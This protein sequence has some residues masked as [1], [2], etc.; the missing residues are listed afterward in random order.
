MSRYMLWNDALAVH[1]FNAD[2]AGKEVYLHTTWDLIEKTGKVLGEP[3][4]GFLE[5]V[6]DGPPWVGTGTLCQRAYQS[7]K[8]WRSRGLRLPP[9]IGYLCLFVLAATVQGDFAPHAYYPRLWQ[10]LGSEDRLMPPSFDRIWE[11]WEDLEQWSMRD[12]RGE[13]GV[14]RARTIGRHIHVGYPLAQALLSAPDWKQLPAIFAAAGL[15]PVFST[16]EELQTALLIH[17][18]GLLS[19][20]TTRIL[21]AEYGD[22]ACRHLLELVREELREWD[23]AIPAQEN[24]E[25]ATI[26]KAV[27]WLRI[28]LRSV[29]YVANTA[30]AVIRYQLN[31]EFPET[32]LCLSLPD[33]RTVTALPYGDGWSMPLCLPGDKEL[34]A[35][36]LG[37][38]DDVVLKDK[39][40]GWVFRLPGR[41]ARVFTSGEPWGLP[42]LV[43]VPFLLS[44]RLGIAV[45]SQL[46]DALVSWGRASCLGFT[47]PREIKG[48]PQ[49]WSL[50]WIDKV[51]TPTNLPR[52]L[53]F[54][55]PPP[56]TRI[57]L[58]GGI[59]ANRGDVF[60]TFAPPRVQVEGG[61]PGARVYCNG[62]PAEESGTGGLYTLPKSILEEPMSRILIEVC[63]ETGV[64]ARRSILLQ[65][66]FEWRFGD[67]TAAI[68]AYG[69]PAQGI[70]PSGIAGARCFERTTSQHERSPTVDW[71]RLALA[72]FLAGRRAFLVGSMP[73][74]VIEWSPRKLLP[75]WEP[76]W[77]IFPGRK[78]RVVFCG[79]DPG[80]AA[81]VARSA[82]CAKHTKLW[83]KLLWYR[84][85]RLIAPNHPE[86]RSLWER[87][88]EVARHADPGRPA[89]VC[90]VCKTGD[91]LG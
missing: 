89:A 67:P 27:G 85:K 87:Y 72:E 12:M 35:S 90:I 29:D 77:A 28:C 68:D 76:A 10:L 26:P 23:G 34:D 63:D 24:D 22:E 57:R 4:Q 8:D 49:G 7:M 45:V 44:G 32:G 30:R 20:R 82:G 55:A 80:T 5:A 25:F 56:V 47:E 15:D 33:G 19:T 84:R 73:G 66:D 6:K 78:R 50:A 81:P 41:P 31:T 43:E 59:R 74:Q 58:V 52:E 60:F 54:L 53:R 61:P 51:L 48:L 65:K 2:Q 14:F 37:W 3:A 71:W 21:R 69:R 86:L 13:L 39:T 11:L 91:Q 75:V 79:R 38:E 64:I 42:G 17:G 83:K 9:Y 88:K 40:L 18:R 1:F 16:Q 46:R 62:Q 70:P 36:E